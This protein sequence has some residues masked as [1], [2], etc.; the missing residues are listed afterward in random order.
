MILDL[1]QF[2][3]SMFLGFDGGLGEFIELVSRLEL[4]YLEV[5]CEPGLLYP[6]EISPAKKVELKKA[7]QEHEVTPTVHASFYDINLASLN[8]LIREASA[9]QLLEC[10]KLAHDLGAEIVVVHPGELPGD[11]PEDCLPLSREN[12]IEGLQGALE[13]AEELGVTI[14]LENKAR[15]RNRG[16]IHS[17]K[18]HL[19]L[20]EAL[21]SPNCRVA[22][23]VGHAHT[24][25]LDLIGYLE[26][27][28]PHLVEVHLHDNDGSMDYHRPLGGGTI[29]FEPLLLALSQWGYHGPL[30]LEMTSVEDLKQS[31]EYLNRIRTFRFG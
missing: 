24:F 17:P 29:E 9:R 21:D 14:A 11:Y 13:L 2:G 3:A 10:I 15:G 28:L 1:K 25:G 5:K 16:L 31:K 20:I 19:D 8:P 7:L 18:E 6:R 27:V 4:G 12:F 22:F 23:D 30:I 26:R